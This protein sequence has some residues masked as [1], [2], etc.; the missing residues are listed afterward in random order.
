VRGIHIEHLESR[1]EGEL[2][3]QGLLGLDENVRPGFQKITAHFRAK[4]NASAEQLEDLLKYSV[5]CDTVCRPVDVRPE[6][7]MID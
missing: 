4:A 5:V 6:V 7:E 2:D 1:L 3:L